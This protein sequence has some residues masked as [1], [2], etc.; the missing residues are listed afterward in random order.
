M[1]HDICTRDG[2]AHM[3][4]VGETPWHGLGTALKEPATSEEA[5]KAA[6]LDWRVMKVPLY[7][8]EFGR[9]MQVPGAFAVVRA[10]L[11]DKEDQDCPIFGVVSDAY[12]P[13]Q[14]REAFAFFDSIVG[15]KAAVYHTAGALGD[16]ERVWILAKL[17]EH[18]QVVGDDVADK[19]LLLANDHRGEGS[20]LMKFTSVRVV[21]NNTLTLALEGGST[22]RVSHHRNVK[23]RLEAAKELLGIIQKGFGEM[24]GSFRAMA[25]KSI[26]AAGLKEYVGAVFPLPDNP[27][28]KLRSRIGRDRTLAE[29]FFAEGKGNSE[30][31]VKGTLWAAF[32]GVTELIDHRLSP[33]AQGTKGA[34]GRLRSVMFGTGAATKARAYK[35][36]VGLTKGEPLPT[37]KPKR[38][39]RKWLPWLGAGS[40]N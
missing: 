4:Y 1:A 40:T 11:W 9:R 34:E 26:T 23:A 18:L 27:E 28:D 37:A 15:E 30:K 20:V 13:V 25:A 36:A 35:L 8:A 7:A 12:T 14:N 6:H 21:C 24:Q 2:Q 10:D 31:G 33:N 39:R 38:P 17:P 3:M 22:I 5:I 19:Y 29:H 16:G 32:N